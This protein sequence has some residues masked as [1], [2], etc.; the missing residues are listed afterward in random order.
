MPGA[1]EFDF[2]SFRD[3]TSSSDTPD[4][5]A[6]GMPDMNLD[7]VVNNEDLMMPDNDRHVPSSTIDGR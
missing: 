6:F 4:I 7:G 1:D 3:S 2:G 5:R